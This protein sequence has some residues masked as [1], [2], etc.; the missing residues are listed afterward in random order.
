[1]IQDQRFT[2]S[3]V[4]GHSIPPRGPARHGDRGSA[5]LAG[6]VN[7]VK[8]AAHD[9]ARWN[10]RVNAI[11]PGPFRTNLGG[12]GPMPPEARR[13]GRRSSRSAGWATPRR[14]AAWPC[15]LIL[16]A[17]EKR[18]DESVVVVYYV[19]PDV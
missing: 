19:G 12:G 5:V 11:A 6:V 8:Q 4:P 14:F 3:A 7:F 17:L 1:M 18:D 15:Y 16:W 9:L 2:P 13:D 10:V